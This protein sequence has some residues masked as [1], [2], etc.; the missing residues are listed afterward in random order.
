MMAKGNSIGVW[1]S[2]DRAASMIFRHRRFNQFGDG[3]VQI[4]AIGGKNQKNFDIFIKML[5]FLFEVGQIKI[6]F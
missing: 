4:R 6:R 5:D 2:R 3:G 1:P